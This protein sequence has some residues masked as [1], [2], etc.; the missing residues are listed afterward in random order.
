MIIITLFVSL[1]G[2]LCCAREL[3]STVQTSQQFDEGGVL[4][5]FSVFLLFFSIAFSEKSN[6][7]FWRVLTQCSDTLIPFIID[8]NDCHT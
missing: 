3:L 5:C 6:R 4:F 8:R 1:V 7:I 2:E